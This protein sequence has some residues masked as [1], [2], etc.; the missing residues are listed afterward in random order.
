M[1]ASYPP[2]PFLRTDLSSGLSYGVAVDDASVQFAWG[3]QVQS[4]N[5]WIAIGSQTGIPPTLFA[6]GPS[7]T[8]VS[9]NFVAQGTGGFNFGNYAGQLF[10]VM[11]PADTGAVTYY[12]PAVLSSSDGGDFVTYTANSG[13]SGI[14]IDIIIA[15]LS[16]GNVIAG[17]G[18]Q[19]SGFNGFVGGNSC[20][21]LANYTV[22]LGYNCEADGVH[23]QAYGTGTWTHGSWGKRVYGSSAQLT[24]NLGS[25]QNG[26]QTLAITT[27]GTTPTVLTAD[28]AG[29]TGAN[30]LLQVPGNG[31]WAVSIKVVAQESVNVYGATW[32]INAQIRRPAGVATIVIDGSTGTGAPTFSSGSPASTWT[33]T[34]GTNTTYGCGTIIV[35][36]SGTNPIHWCAGVHSTEVTN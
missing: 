25:A 16:N 29:V 26:E 12:W 3:D 27:T 18:H 10:Q 8:S 1:S 22:A 17:V 13:G 4:V 34:L 24:S 33:V 5:F 11:S 19:H 32:F 15:P 23:S 30:I 35:T 6:G 2:F 14:Q 36:G 9:G 21:I 28:N 31:T 20:Y 7:N